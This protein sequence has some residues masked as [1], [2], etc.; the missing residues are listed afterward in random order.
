MWRVQWRLM[1]AV[2]AQWEGRARRG[3]GTTGEWLDG[4]RHSWACAEH[5]RM[6][7]HQ[8]RWR[9]QRQSGRPGEGRCRQINKQSLGRSGADRQRAPRRR[10]MKGAAMQREQGSGVP[11]P[12]GVRKGSK[13]KAGREGKTFGREPQRARRCELEQAS[14]PPIKWTPRLGATV[15]NGKNSDAGSVFAHGSC[16]AD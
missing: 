3:L 12:V 6:R 9:E 4:R 16:R 5:K 10:V 15:L 1:L 7:A 13:G 14:G 11:V 8:W 2:L